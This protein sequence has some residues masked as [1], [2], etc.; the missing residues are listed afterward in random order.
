MCL[1][2]SSWCSCAG[3]GPSRPPDQ[4]TRVSGL[5]AR[6]LSMTFSRSDLVA[7]SILSVCCPVFG[8]FADKASRP[9]CFGVQEAAQRCLLTFV[10][11]GRPKST[12]REICHIS[13]R[14]AGIR[15]EVSPCLNGTARG[16]VD[17]VD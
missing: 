13:D 12:L 10:P 17:W 7:T 3:A 2:T 16:L 4:L 15:S 1:W 5:L 6:V 11:A 8:L 14:I 9:V